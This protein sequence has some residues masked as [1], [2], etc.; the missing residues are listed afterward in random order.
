MG[1]KIEKIKKYTGNF[2]DEFSLAIKQKKLEKKVAKEKQLQEEIE[3][4]MTKSEAEKAKIEAEKERLKQLNDKE[5]MVELIFAVRG[6]YSQFTSLESKC[7]DLAAKLSD[8][9]DAIQSLEDDIEDLQSRTN[10]SDN[11]TN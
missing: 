1:E 4:E 2:K 6:F 9:E 8:C 5:L 10:N 7:E 11:E 3:A